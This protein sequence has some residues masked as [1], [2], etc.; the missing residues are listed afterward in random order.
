MLTIVYRGYLIRTNRL[1][2][3]VWIEKGGACIAMVKSVEDA[4]REID[5]LGY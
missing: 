4:K 3:A 2:G 1:N 5:G